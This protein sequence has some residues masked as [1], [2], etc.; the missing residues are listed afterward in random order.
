MDATVQCMAREQLREE[1]SR[2]RVAVFL[3]RAEELGFWWQSSRQVAQRLDVPDSSFR[4]HLRRREQLT[5]DPGLSPS[6]VRFL[7]SL[8]GVEFLH[9]LLVAL[10]L[11]FGLA[12]DCGLRNI[13]WFLRL[14]RL[15][16]ILPASYGAQQ[17]F[18]VQLE[19]LLAEFGRAEE[20]RLAAQMPHREISLCADETFHPQICLVA[21]EPVSN[22]LVLE[23]Y[24]PQR[25]AD[26]WRQCLDERLKGWSVTVCQVA[27]DEAKALIA[28]AEDRL[29]ARS[30]ARPVPCAARDRACHQP[31][32]GR[33][34][35]TSSRGGRRRRAAPHRAARN[36]GPARNN[37]RRAYTSPNSS[38]TSRKP[39]LRTPPP[40]NG[41]RPV[42]SANNRPP[43]RVTGSH[44]T[45]TQSTSRRVGRL[46][47]RRSRSD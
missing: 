34:D 39:L 20:Q 36:S 35:P 18:A 45:T 1:S 12:N 42:S 31:G 32:A 4:Y 28:L 47:H 15:D 27:S 13:S 41:S 2:F 8:T 26:M 37:A 38:S 21:M 33:A 25:D 29:G 43:R 23:Q 5:R 22:Y 44:T 14:T 10:H 46:R 11:V 7:E 16:K 6:L 17:A 3:Q 30:L 24:A 9:R 19:T 40:G